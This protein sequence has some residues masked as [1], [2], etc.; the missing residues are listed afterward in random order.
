M[1]FEKT[2]RISAGINLVPLINI[3]FL[4]LIFFMLSTTLVMPE[5]EA[6]EVPDSLNSREQAKPTLSII[7]L[8]DGTIYFE[9]E[10]IAIDNLASIFPQTKNMNE[11]PSLLIKA[12]V[13]VKTKVVRQIIEYARAGGIKKVALATQSPSRK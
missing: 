3:V 12:D 8:T 11:D 7:I 1:D 9:N 2:K 13:D 6:L 4:L 10:P 5:P